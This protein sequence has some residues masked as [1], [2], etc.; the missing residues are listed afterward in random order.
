MNL[1]VPRV[2]EKKIKRKKNVDSRDRKSRDERG[3]RFAK[4]A[5]TRRRGQ[6]K[7]EKA[8]SGFAR[9]DQIRSRGFE[10]RAT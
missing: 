7:F 9:F 5:A 2:N 10:K 6:I 3:H 8:E 1:P 4:S